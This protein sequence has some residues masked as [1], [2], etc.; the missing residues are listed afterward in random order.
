MTDQRSADATGDSKR[1]G[2]AAGAS[3]GGKRPMGP[4]ARERPPVPPASGKGDP[5][6]PS[7]PRRSGWIWVGTLVVL[8]LWNL[9]L[10]MDVGAPSAAA[11]PYSEFI[12]QT[13]AGNVSSVQLD[14]QS[15]SG[16]FVQ[17]VVW[18]PASGVPGATPAPTTEPG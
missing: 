13:K 14:G 16:T 1:R 12:S 2:E 5:S 8:L 11:V 6:S 18:P 3:S 9:V 10:F 17:P 7:G 4:P 15:V